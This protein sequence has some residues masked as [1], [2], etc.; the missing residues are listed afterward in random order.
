MGQLVDEVKPQY[1]SKM[2]FVVVNVDNAS[3]QAVAQK[4]NVQYVPLTVMF[5][6]KGTQAKTYT[7]VVAKDALIAEI[8]AL[9]K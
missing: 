8:Q 9:V 2:N 4:Y 3:E 1:Q 5:D 6:S 7:G